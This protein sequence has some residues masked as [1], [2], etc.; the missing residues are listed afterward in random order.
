MQLHVDAWD[1]AYGSGF[2]ADAEPAESEA[3]RDVAVER[4]ADAWQPLTPPPTTRAPSAVLFVD[5]VRR[6]DANV[7]LV[8]DDGTSHPGLA[9]SYA[10]GVVR[11]DGTAR[12]VEQLVRRGL[13]TASEDA[14]DV[15]SP[16]NS[17]VH[18][19]VRRVAGAEG[20]RFRGAED[21]DTLRLAVQ[22]ELASTEI[23]VSESA[24]EAAAAYTE[25]ELAPDD[26]LV[27]DGPLRG[28]G[29][30]PRTVGYVK[31]HERRYLPAELDAVVADLR[32][33][34][35]TPVF[36][37]GTRWQRYAWYLKLPTLAAMPWAGVV[38]VECAAELDAA[39]ATWLAD[40]SAVSL[41][42]YA[43][44]EFRDP[45]APQN[46]VPVAGLERALRTR[47]GDVRVLRRGLRAAAGAGRPVPAG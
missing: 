45:R 37:M 9:A 19:P 31:S 39:E 43:S 33:G 28:R 46:L 47:L 30:L 17:A 34:Q 18:F 26:L 44:R 22:D 24:R 5:G 1:P 36:A 40:L 10:A 35:R 8:S 3:L 16:H 23:V 38:R 14:G 42:R 32:A 11:C 27:V 29:H 2:E 12:V 20:S 15:T 13:F 25:G 6:L 21:L 41:P 7:W 4:P